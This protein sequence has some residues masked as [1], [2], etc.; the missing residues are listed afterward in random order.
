M[1]RKGLNQQVARLVLATCFSFAT[2]LSYAAQ[3][4]ASPRILW[5]DA[6]GDT[7]SVQVT[8]ISG[9]EYTAIRN[10]IHRQQT[11]EKRFIVKVRLKHTEPA[12]IPPLSGRYTLL[13]SGL[14]FEPEFPFSPGLEYQAEY[15]PINP[16]QAGSHPPAI[17]STFALPKHQSVSKATVSAVY[18][19]ADVLPENLLKFYLHFSHAMSRGD[20]YRHIT[21]LD[22]KDK[23]IDLPFLEIGEELWDPE[24]KRL[25]LLIDP[26]RI[27]RGVKP[28]EDIG[29]A[30]EAY[31]EYTLHISRHWQDGEGAPL[32]TDFR[33][34]FRVGP[35][36]RSAP[37]PLQWKIDSPRAGTKQSLIIRFPKSMDHALATRVIWIESADGKP[38][39]G[40]VTLTENE[41]LWSLQPEREW[42]TGHY[43]IKAQHILEDLAGNSI[44]RPFEIDV[45]ERVDPDIK[46]VPFV[47]RFTVTSN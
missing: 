19:S 1:I 15:H 16:T 20:V 23:P 47:I 29:P 34:T 17:R 39:V 45:F 9:A 27:K 33:K 31:H 6:S 46:E 42:V 10:A 4:I 40:N 44:G 38:V 37:N 2:Q 8:G 35:P 22:D 36:D 24:Q 3:P 26:G 43:R 28:L 11:I 7:P 32:K 41:T 12:E 30:I 5:K 25:T 18:P 14:R 21:L 13:E